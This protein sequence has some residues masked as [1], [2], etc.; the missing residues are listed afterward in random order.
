MGKS[1]P[2]SV[3]SAK[4]RL[5]LRWRSMLS[6]YTSVLKALRGSPEKKSTSSL[7]AESAHVPF[8]VPGGAGG[9][10]NVL[11]VLQEVGHCFPLNVG[12]DRL[13]QAIAGPPYYARI[14]DRGLNSAG[15][16]P[17]SYLHSMSSYRHPWRMQLRC[18]RCQTTPTVAAPTWDESSAS[19]RGAGVYM[20]R[21][22]FGSCLPADGLLSLADGMNRGGRLASS[23]RMAAGVDWEEEGV[24]GGAS[25]ITGDKLPGRR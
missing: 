14:S 21:G 2:R 1:V 24:G 3:I 15:W 7:C 23:D 6:E 13:I 10:T 20:C 8:M 12:E 11:E 17:Y 25:M 5:A 22:C 4:V 19:R 18:R 16:P 9:A